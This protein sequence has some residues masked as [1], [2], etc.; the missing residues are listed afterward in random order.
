MSTTAAITIDEITRRIAG[1]LK[2]HGVR[3]C[4]LF[5]SHARNDASRHSDVD[6]LLIKSTETRFLDRTRELQYELSNLLPETDV[7][8]LCYTPEELQR[9]KPRKFI[10]TILSEGKVI[11]ERQ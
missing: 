8:V 3:Q 2:T 11:Y 9:M 5:G 6:L 7:D 4:I 10:Q 1:T